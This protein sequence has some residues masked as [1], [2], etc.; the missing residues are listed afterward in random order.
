MSLS[1]LREGYRAFVFGASGGIG[2]AFVRALSAD[3]RCGGVFAGA[4]RP[5]AHAPKAAPFRFDLLDE[6]SIA[7]AAALG[8]RGEADLVIVASGKLHD[9]ALQPEKSLR[10]LDPA[11]LARSF[12]VNAVGPALIAKHMLPLMPRERKSVFAA[13]SARVGSIS[14]NR[15]GGW[16]GYRAAKAALNQ[17]IRTSAIELAQKNKQAAC[18][19]LHPGTV[20]TALSKPFQAGVKTHALLSPDESA[21]HLLRVM[22]QLSAQ[23]SGG[24]FAWD[25]TP[26]PF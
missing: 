19:A 22:D 25:G 2:A 16:Y 21:G 3:P 5:L 8:E 11:A 4:R 12:A 20:D 14:D 9:Q 17:L 13:L 26:I 1:T 15:S 24:C 7:A 10:A 18:V 23:D 6:A